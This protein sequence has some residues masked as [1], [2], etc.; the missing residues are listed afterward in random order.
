M[1]VFNFLIVFLLACSN[2]TYAETT[3]K[4]ESSLPAQ[5]YEAKYMPS[6]TAIAKQAQNILFTLS[7]GSQWKSVTSAEFFPKWT[8][9][10]K[11]LVR[12]DNNSKQ[13]FLHDVTHDP[14]LSKQDAETT[15]FVAIVEAPALKIAQVDNTAHTVTLSDGTILEWV[16]FVGN[17]EV[18]NRAFFSL[19][20]GETKA[21]FPYFFIGLH[22][23]AD[24]K[25]NEMSWQ[26]QGE[27]PARLI[28][29]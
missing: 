8:V 16:P 7:D 11:V 9:G 20:E 29:K 2:A 25:T 15:I 26:P 14:L 3:A 6:I 27:V 1:H 23:V 13:Y 18:G 10:N 19:N 24:P 4:V 28:S 21:A 22:R 12:W 5:S 17:L